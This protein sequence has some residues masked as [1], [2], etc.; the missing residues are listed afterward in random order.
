MIARALAAMVLTLVGLMVPLAGVAQEDEAPAPRAQAVELLDGEVVIPRPTGW[1]IIRPGQGARA[2]FRSAA[3]SL[4]Q[5]EVRVSDSVSA[6]RWERYWRT[7]DN[8]LR[9]AGFEIYSSRTE[10]AFAGRR[11]LFFEYE[12][13]RDGDD[14]RL[15][16]W[17]THEGDRAWIFTGFFSR[18]RRDAHL[19]TFEE[20]L[21]N[22]QW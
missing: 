1:N 14:Y 16:V 8:D 17:H 7:F 18:A 10:R 2:T 9:R 4:A 22:I 6:P 5:I 12:L 21:E 13:E 11:G 3:D 20:M 19:S 15:V